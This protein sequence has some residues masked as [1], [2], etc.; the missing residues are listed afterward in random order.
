MNTFVMGNQSNKTKQ[1]FVYG[2]TDIFKNQAI[3]N[4]NDLKK[5]IQIEKN[6]ITLENTDN[7]APSG[8]GAISTPNYSG[9]HQAN[10][11]KRLFRFIISLKLDFILLFFI[12]RQ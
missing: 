4:L 7:N 10:I 12:F 6:K 3:S 9:F 8:G 1:Y 5:G 2:N 11:F